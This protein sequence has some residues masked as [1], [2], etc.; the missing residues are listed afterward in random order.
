M[1]KCSLLLSHS[2]GFAYIRHPLLEQWAIDNN[3]T[4][5]VFHGDF[6]RVIYITAVEYLNG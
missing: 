2:S 5:A 1:F 4:M 6:V 3:R